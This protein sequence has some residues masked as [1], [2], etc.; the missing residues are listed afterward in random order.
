MQLLKN[1]LETTSAERVSYDVLLHYDNSSVESEVCE[2][3][4]T[5]E[6]GLTRESCGWN[7]KMQMLGMVCGPRGT[8]QGTL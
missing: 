2:V 8:P 3:E 4:I 6:V 5:S 1:S 7:I